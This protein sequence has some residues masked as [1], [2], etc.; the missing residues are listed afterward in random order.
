LPTGLTPI[1]ARQRLGQNWNHKIFDP[2]EGY[3]I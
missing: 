1:T 2:S 3:A